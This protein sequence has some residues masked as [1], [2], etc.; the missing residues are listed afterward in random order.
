MKLRLPTKNI[1]LP[2]QYSKLTKVSLPNPLPTHEKS[3]YVC[4]HT[5]Y[6]SQQTVHLLTNT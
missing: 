6:I 3:R 2:F 4:G 1:F 5:I